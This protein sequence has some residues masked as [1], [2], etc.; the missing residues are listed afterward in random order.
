VK[1]RVKQESTS[2]ESGLPV[3]ADSLAVHH[4]SQG[5]NWARSSKGSLLSAGDE[6]AALPAGLVEPD[7]DVAL[8]VLAQ[9]DVG[10]GP[11]VL[12][13]KFIRILI[14]RIFNNMLLNHFDKTNKNMPLIPR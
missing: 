4:R 13:H 6:S 7:C 11:V 8:P 5:L 3:V 2:A 12:N 14:I 1:P 10:D 9:V